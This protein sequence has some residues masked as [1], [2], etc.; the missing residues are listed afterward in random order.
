V[1]RVLESNLLD[2]DVADDTAFSNRQLGLLA[3]TS[4]PIR[5][6]CINTRFLH[7]NGVLISL[8]A[9]LDENLSLTDTVVIINQCAGEMFFVGWHVV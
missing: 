3:C 9:Q 8:L 6:R 4:S 1:Q 2:D 7:G 5:P